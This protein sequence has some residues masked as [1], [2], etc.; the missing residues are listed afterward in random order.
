MEKETLRISRDEL[1]SKR[2]VMLDFVAHQLDVYNNNILSKFGVT[3]SQ[4]K[5]LVRLS[6]SPEGRLSQKE[7]S[8]MG[9]RNST[10]T[11]IL[12]N[13]EKN[14]YVM[15][16]AD[17]SDARAKL[18]QITPKGLEV[19]QMALKNVFD[20]ENLLTEGFSSEEKILFSMLLKRAV[21]NMMK[22]NKLEG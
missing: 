16:V 15:R 10:I 6:E 22:I 19:Q 7:L 18:I 3:H 20:L 5:I 9:R 8:M 13:L 4:A 12:N 2:A 1:I 14:G 11:A 17:E 21:D